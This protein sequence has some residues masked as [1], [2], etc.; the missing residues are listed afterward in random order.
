MISK[1]A[2]L[3][4]PINDLLTEEGDDGK[5]DY[6]GAVYPTYDQDYSDQRKEVVQATAHRWPW[7]LWYILYI[8][9]LFPWRMQV[10]VTQSSI[11][12]S[13]HKLKDKMLQLYMVE[14]IITFIMQKECQDVLK[15]KKPSSA[16]DRA[17][18]VSQV[19]AVIQ[20]F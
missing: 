13:V 1:T 9:Y 10:Q 16:D 7:V 3:L 2:K 17:L 14:N 18:L 12:K 20:L 5:M 15:K 19:S 4:Q 8:V 11:Q 6:A